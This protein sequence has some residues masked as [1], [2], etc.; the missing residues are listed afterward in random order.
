MVV[1]L[2]PGDAL[3]A[4]STSWNDLR[5]RTARGG[6]PLA[7]EAVQAVAQPALPT[8]DVPYSRSNSDGCAAMLAFPSSHLCLPRETNREGRSPLLRRL[9]IQRPLVSL[10]DLIGDIET[11]AEVR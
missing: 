11:E 1:Y 10:H 9:D 5:L 8:I 7:E 4:L 3:C 6:L 2:R